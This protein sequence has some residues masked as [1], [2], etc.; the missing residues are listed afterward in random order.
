M[1]TTIKVL[2]LLRL[3]H[4]SQVT[5][6][7]TCLSMSSHDCDYC[8][9][10]FT[11][12]DSRKRH[13]KTC[14]VKEYLINPRGRQIEP[15][16]P[17]LGPEVTSPRPAEPASPLLGPVLPTE[18]TSPIETVEPPSPTDTVESV[19]PTD[20]TKVHIDPKTGKK[21]M[22]DAFGDPMSP[23]SLKPLDIF[24]EA[25][26]SPIRMEDDLS[27][28]DPWDV[29]RDRVKT[30]KL[31]DFKV[32]MKTLQKGGLSKKRAKVRAYNQMLSEFQ[33]ALRH[34]YIDHLKW[35]HVLR[36]DPIHKAILETRNRMMDE[37]EMDYDEAVEAAVNQRKYLLNRVFQPL[38]E[39]D[40]DEEDEEDDED[41]DED[42]M[43]ADDEEDSPEDESPE[44]DS[45]EDD[46]PEEDS[47]EDE[48]KQFSQGQMGYIPGPSSVFVG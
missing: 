19:K 28:M 47:L 16:S 1:K 27:D 10:K 26:T 4:F 48:G 8:L 42:D 25:P 34:V 6:Q 23:D 9:K 13:E 41:E 43:D 11:R 5:K 37:E 20:P 36:E 44:E 32:V 7:C 39:P 35:V 22:Y 12:A 38:E 46:S 18:P 24:P 30:L 3:P 17:L 14:K 29:F 33:K 15:T 2:S 21:F 45:P 40:T 31:K